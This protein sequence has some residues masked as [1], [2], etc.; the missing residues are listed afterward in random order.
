MSCFLL[1]VLA[2]CVLG[3]PSS[4]L[5]SSS[6]QFGGIEGL[7]LT[8]EGKP[9][10]GATV[11]A[12]EVSRP[13]VGRPPTAVSDDKGH[14]L[15]NELE[16]GPYMVYGAKEEENYPETD[17]SFY[18]LMPPPEVTVEAGRIAK[19]VVLRFGAKAA[20]L[21][22]KVIDGQTGRDISN[23][24]MSLFRADDLDTIGGS[25]SRTG[26]FTALIPPDNPIRVKVTAPGYEDWYYGADG[27]EDHAT[28]I[29]LSSGAKKELTVS[30]RP[31]NKQ[32]S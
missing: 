5:P 26:V 6:E 28:P 11:S 16:P 30:L 25:V 17:I 21:V 4:V 20:R 15:I 31:L 13:F 1:A 32:A 19:N 14:Y 10:A 29:R 2:A 23:A 27:T 9:V 22:G 8:A 18:G 3:V 24:S 12:M 7:V